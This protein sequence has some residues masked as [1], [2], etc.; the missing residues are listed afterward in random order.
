[1]KLTSG[2]LSSPSVGNMQGE[3]GAFF[4]EKMKTAAKKEHL[5]NLVANSFTGRCAFQKISNLESALL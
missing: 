2:E 1:V 3:N 4:H 5:F